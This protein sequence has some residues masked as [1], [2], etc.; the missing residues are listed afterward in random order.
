MTYTH[1]TS[2]EL[3]MLTLVERLSKVIITL[4]PEGRR[5]I[6]IENRLNQWMKS[7]PKHLLDLRQYL[8]HILVETVTPFF[9]CQRFKLLWG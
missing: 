2:N 8:G 9:F 4:Q 6:D 1:L 3:A 7:V 5:A